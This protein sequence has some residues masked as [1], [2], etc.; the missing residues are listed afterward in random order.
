MGGA[1]GLSTG[2]GMTMDGL[3][4]WNRGLCEKSTEKG[5]SLGEGPMGSYPA[6]QPL[7]VLPKAHAS[8]FQ[9]FQ[10][11]CGLVAGA[12]RAPELALRG[13]EGQSLQPG[14]GGSGA[15]HAVPSGQ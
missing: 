2:S 9:G 12:W 4:P 8:S 7:R 11:L 13:G 15:G 1:L 10:L 3:G 5:G 6:V 14:R